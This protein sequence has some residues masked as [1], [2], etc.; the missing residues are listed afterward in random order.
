MSIKR[1]CVCVGLPFLFGRK[2][3]TR[4]TEGNEEEEEEGKGEGERKS[5]GRVGHRVQRDRAIAHEIERAREADKA[6]IAHETYKKKRLPFVKEREKEVQRRGGR[7]A[8]N[9]EIG[10]KWESS[11]CTQK[12]IRTRERW[13]NAPPGLQATAIGRHFY[14]ISRPFV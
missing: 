7:D 2:R 4:K 9:D 6:K 10:E 5:G 3:E 13:G 11:D 8:G 1:S 14:R 12:G